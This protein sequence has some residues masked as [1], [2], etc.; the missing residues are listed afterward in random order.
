MLA[1]DAAI[2][3]AAMEYLKKKGIDAISVDVIA[4]GCCGAP[5]IRNASVSKGKPTR[6]ANV[7]K[8][9]TVDGID[10]Y[11]PYYTNVDDGVVRIDA[12]R[13]LGITTLYV[14]NAESEY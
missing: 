9:T 8:K 7:Y 3:P 1:K 11:Y 6:D 12:E 14:A 4:S 5:G 2:A 13:F 10:V